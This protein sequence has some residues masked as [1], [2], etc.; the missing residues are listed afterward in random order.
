M[1]PIILNAARVYAPY[2]VWPVAAVVGFIGYHIET[3]I[4]GEDGMNTPA[5]E[6]SIIEEREERRLMENREKNLTDV[7]SLKEGKFIPKTIFT[8]VQKP[9]NN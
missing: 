7:D 8:N 5:K 9:S 1:W 3:G 6:H 2:I 4:R